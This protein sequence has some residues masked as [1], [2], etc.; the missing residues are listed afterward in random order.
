MLFRS[1]ALERLQK[2]GD[3][4]LQSKNASFRNQYDLAAYLYNYLRTRYGKQDLEPR[5]GNVELLLRLLN[6]LKAANARE[7]DPILWRWRPLDG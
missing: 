5:M 4:R 7:L 2:A 6:R 1:I 3:A